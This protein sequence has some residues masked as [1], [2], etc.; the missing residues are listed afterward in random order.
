MLNAR[1]HRPTAAS[2][3]RMRG[4]VVADAAQRYA[5]HRYKGAEGEIVD[6]MIRRTLHHFPNVYAIYLD[7]YDFAHRAHIEEGDGIGVGLLLDAET[8]EQLK[9]SGYYNKVKDGWFTLCIEIGDIADC[10]YSAHVHPIY[11]IDLRWRRRIAKSYERIYCVDAD[12]ARKFERDTLAEYARL[13]Q[14]ESRRPA[15]AV[16]EGIGEL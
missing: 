1:Q 4:A 5:V 2:P 13:E 12:A 7:P 6:R 3:A 8:T 14:R 15:H 9:P 16:S 11:N 10:D